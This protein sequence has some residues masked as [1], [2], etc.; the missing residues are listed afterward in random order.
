MPGWFAPGEAEKAA[1]FI[2][3]EWKEFKKKLIVDY[4]CGGI[5][6]DQYVWRPRRITGDEGLGGN[7]ISVASWGSA[8]N[9]GTCVFLKE[10]RCS[11]HAVKPWEC[12]QTM[13][14]DG[15]NHRYYRKE[16]MEI[17]RASGDRPEEA[18]QEI[19]K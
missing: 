11:I 3:A 1:K 14:C 2:G 4:W 7:R 16:L 17:W 9:E 18:P 19:E 12:R 15:T 10:G 5:G 8:F 13:C 6:G